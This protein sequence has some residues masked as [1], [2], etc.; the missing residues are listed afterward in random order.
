MCGIL[1]GFGQNP[2]ETWVREHLGDLAQRGPDFSQVSVISQNCVMGNTRLAMTDPH[3]RSHQPF[4]NQQSGSSIVFNGEIYNY[5]EIR[6]SLLESGIIFQ[7]ESD[8]EVL[9]KALDFLGIEKTNLMNGMYSFAYYHKQMNTLFLGRDSLGKKPLYYFI[10]SKEIYWSSSINS[11]KS[12]IYNQSKTNKR[13]SKQFVHEYLT[14]GYGLDPETPEKKI[15][16]VLPGTVLKIEFN[17]DS[18]SI[19]ELKI[20]DYVSEISKK[21]LRETIR[22]AV[23]R[24]VEGHQNNIALSLSG[25]IDST[26]IAIS[27]REIFVDA[28]SFSAIWTDSDKSRYNIDAAVATNIAKKLGFN[29]HVIEMPQSREVPEALDHFLSSMQEPN[30]NPS[31][32]SMNHLYSKISS[33]GNR[34]VLTGDGADEIFGGYKRYEELSKL[35]QIYFMK[36]KEYRK[37]YGNMDGL[38]GLISKILISQTT[39]IPPLKWARWHFVFSPNELN[40]LTELNS[41]DSSVFNNLLVKLK[42]LSR[43]NVKLDQVKETM[44]YDHAIW[45]AMESNRKLDRISMNFSIEARSPFQDEEVIHLGRRLMETS[46]YRKINKIILKQ[47]YPELVNLGV[48]KD[49]AG[50]TSPVG[51]WLRSN[52]GLVKSSLQKCHEVQILSQSKSD[53]I[54]EFPYSGDYRKLM[55]AWTLVVLGRFLEINGINSVE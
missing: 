4:I 14:F 47:E 9:L 31:G 37:I 26:V 55:Q 38:K 49:K 32:L 3:P 24:R 19:S 53:S 40:E 27:L 34:L 50:F 12:K 7:T 35:P 10:E 44:Y 22:D 21:S 52:P 15:K 25:G 20:G 30:N 1:G 51:H 17:N 43:I 29:H 45:L 13:I 54:N 28:N 41:L 5:K 6:N 39:D 2:S 48:R 18:L 23:A 16:S 46:K 11:L 42:K 8:T 33:F 36:K